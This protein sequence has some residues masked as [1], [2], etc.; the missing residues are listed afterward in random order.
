MKNRIT[1][2][3]YTHN[4]EDNITSCINSAKLLSQDVRIIDMESFDKTVI[5]AKRLGAKV[6][7]HPFTPY[8]EPAREFGI[9][10]VD[11]GW[12]FLLD[13]DER[14][15]QSLAWEIIKITKNKSNS[16]YKVPRQNIFGKS[17][18]DKWL[19]HGGWWPDYQTRLIFVDDFI[20]W[21]KNI[22]STPTIKGTPGLLTNPLLH[23]F[24]GNLHSMV[25]KTV[26]FENIE[27]DLLF[28]A[29][30]KVGV[31]IF[32]RKFLGELFRRLIK[33]KG[34]FDGTIGIIE[35]VYQ[36]F[37]KTITYIYLYEKKIRAV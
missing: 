23:F 37:S 1:V 29:Q 26:S 34:Y 21:S 14:I 32:F 27:A 30:K 19:K 15:T 10:K 36:A 13:A 12:V 24:H 18:K 25:K 28:Q 33:E 35:C 6:Y 4:E 3:I 31:I 20:S 5:L 7:T 16:Y 22:H 9:K 17:P 11:D 8:V 2:L